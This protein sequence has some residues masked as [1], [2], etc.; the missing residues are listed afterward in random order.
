MGELEIIQTALKRTA[1]RRRTERAL[2]GLWNG[3][4]GGAI[5]TLLVISLNHVLPL[6]LWVV[7]AAPF[8]PVPFMLAGLLAGGWRKAALTETARWV[9]VRQRLHERLSTALELASEPDPGRWSEMVVADAASHVKEIEPHRLVSF[10]L[11][12]GTRWALLALA[13]CAGLGF[14][15][16]YRSKSY[17]QNKKDA[18]NIKNVGK[19]LSELTRRS[20]QA[21]PPAFEPTEKSLDAVAELGDQLAKKTLTRNE[22]LKELSSVADRLKEQINDLG[23]DP[24]LKKL[25]EAARA[26]GGD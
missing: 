7:L 13:L 23:K 21:R 20:L 2:H 4:L 3:L 16:E 5:L 9:D 14:V 8:I 15:P 11:P 12:K 1:H 19:Q 25:Q 10:H 17:L 24:G 6:P 26:S 22:A 18:Q